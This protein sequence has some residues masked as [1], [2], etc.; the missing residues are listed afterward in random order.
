M[1]CISNTAVTK[2]LA[3]IADLLMAYTGEPRERYNTG[4]LTSW[5][6]DRTASPKSEGNSDIHG[7]RA[8]KESNWNVTSF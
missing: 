1:K 2:C 3:G 4:V 7:T 6:L 5:L 8:L